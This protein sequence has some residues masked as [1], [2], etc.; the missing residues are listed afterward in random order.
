MTDRSALVRRYTYLGVPF[1]ALVLV[2]FL[3]GMV[4]N[5][6]VTLPTGATLTVLASPWLDVHLAVGVLLLG[7]AAQGL[8]L[9]IVVGTARDRVVTAAGLIAGLVAF[10]AG[11]S[12]VFGSASAT[13]SYAMSVGFTGLLVEAGYLLW[14]GPARGADD[15]AAAPS[16][17]RS[18]AGGDSDAR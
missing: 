2:E 13:A 10:G 9:A 8:R 15:R 14:T 16:P 11:L 1:L 17:Q 3:L 12:F 4:L 5:L 6:F 18:Y 7:I